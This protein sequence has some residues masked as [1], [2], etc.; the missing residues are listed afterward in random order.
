M[1]VPFVRSITQYPSATSQND[2]SV[3]RPRPT[4]RVPNA[5]S[6]AMAS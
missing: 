3:S 2:F 4:R 5:A 1:I 6:D